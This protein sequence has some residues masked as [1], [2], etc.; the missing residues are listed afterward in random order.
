[1]SKILSVNNLTVHFHTEAGIVRALEDVSF[2]IEEGE[3]LGLVGETGCGKSVTALSV[4][5]LLPVPPG[6]ILGG[7]I[8]FGGRDLLSLNSEEM[9]APERKRPGHDFPGSHEQPEP[10]VYRRLPGRGGHSGP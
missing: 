4:M 1:M 10:G 5:G 8:E 7:T 6:K 2:S 9:R 3:V